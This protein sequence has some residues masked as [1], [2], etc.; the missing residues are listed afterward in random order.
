MGA[1]WAQHAMC[2]SA[3]TQSR[4]LVLNCTY[5]RIGEIFFLRL[6]SALQ[7]KANTF[8]VFHIVA[9]SLVSSSVSC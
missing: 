5:Q 1:A 9:L 6:H 8:F 3:F 4:S 2:E 7:F